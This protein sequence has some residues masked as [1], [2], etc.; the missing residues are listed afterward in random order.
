VAIL[1]D[2]IIG[3]T[4]V[5]EHFQSQ[6]QNQRMHHAF[7]FVGPRGVGRR[8]M[9]FAWA[10]ALLCKKSPMACGFCSSC[11]SVENMLVRGIHKSESL[12]VI[13]P[14]STQIK[15]EQAH[16]VR[17]FLS[18]Q[19]MGQGRVV[20]IDHAEK[21]NQHAANSLLKILEE[22]PEGTSFF[23][24]APTPYHVLSTVRSRSQVVAF[25]TLNREHLKKKNP[26]APDWAVQMAQGSLE[27]LQD[28]TD[29]QARQT[30]EMALSW[31]EDWEKV[32]QAF[33]LS[34]YRDFLKDKGQAQFFCQ[35]LLSIYRDIL[36]LQMH[37]SDILFHPDKKDRLV[38]LAERIPSNHILF[39]IKKLT[40]LEREMDFNFDV[41][42]LLESFWIQTSPQNKK[43]E[44]WNYV[45]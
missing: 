30:R 7:L 6:V 22:P 36:M 13:E 2:K 34:G 24:M 26:S 42:L 21:L 41:Q 1:L 45:Y 15:I 37:R 8:T 18:L 29:D 28:L 40:E 44:F 4:S 31:V 16:E 10:Q 11:L 32:P 35:F 5:V 19:M 3:H 25:S 43:E 38:P 27:K 33:L 9:A 17:D 20:I 23:L 39:V 12:L 14:S